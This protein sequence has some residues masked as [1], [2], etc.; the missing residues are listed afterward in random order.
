MTNIEPLQQYVIRNPMVTKYVWIY[1]YD[2]IGLTKVAQ[3][4]GQL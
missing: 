4:F 2:Q 1:Q 3:I